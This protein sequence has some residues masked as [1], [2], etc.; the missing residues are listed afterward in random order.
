MYYGGFLYLRQH[1]TI[2]CTCMRVLRYNVMTMSGIS[3]SR[4]RT[5][6]LHLIRDHGLKII[7]L[8]PI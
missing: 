6:G 1:C 8:I 7:A 4:N 3:K 2:F 5:S